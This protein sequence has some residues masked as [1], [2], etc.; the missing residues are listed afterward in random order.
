MRMAVMSKAS[1][2]LVSYPK[3]ADFGKVGIGLLDKI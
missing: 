1:E 3:S 2:S